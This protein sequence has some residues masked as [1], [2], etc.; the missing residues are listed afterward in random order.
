[1]ETRPVPDHKLLEQ[2]AFEHFLQHMYT[3]FYED[4]VMYYQPVIG[5]ALSRDSSFGGEPWDYPEDSYA[6]GDVLEAVKAP[7]LGNSRLSADGL[8]EIVAGEITEANEAAL[9]DNLTL[10]VSK[11]RLMKNGNY[12]VR[13]DMGGYRRCDYFLIELAENG[14]VVK[15]VGHRINL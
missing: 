2:F 3:E 7:D 11:R 8:S 5:P 12:L 1:M 6:S 9:W 13:L 10:E 4:E 14:D 15:A